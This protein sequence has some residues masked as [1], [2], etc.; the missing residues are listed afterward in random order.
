MSMSILSV[1]CLTQELHSLEWVMGEQV[2]MP[3][4]D[5]INE[6]DLFEA[7]RRFAK[8]VKLFPDALFRILSLYF[9]LEAIGLE[10]IPK[11]GKALIVPNHSDVFGYDAFMLA[12]LIRHRLKRVP[13]M[14][15]HPFWF[16]NPFFEAVARSYGIFPAD[17]REGLKALKH[18]K[19][20]IIFPEGADGNFKVSSRMYKLVE[21]NPGFVP[22]AIMQKAPVIP[23]VIIGAE[24]TH[25]NVAKIDAFKKI[26]GGPMPVPTGIL[27]RPAK[28][29]IIFLKPIDFSKYTKR[30][31]KDPRFV[32]EINQNI[33]Y[34][35][36][37][38]INKEIK[39]RD[40][41]FE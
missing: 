6:K 14:M 17:L 3:L 13:R 16:N 24:E 40:L 11:H 29:K 35:I 7:G 21:F 18:N 41:A 39:G 25:I 30:D 2:K 26:F 38:V 9:R 37:H 1:N 15:A 36:Q 32:K 5:W 28:W 31:I 10:N 8:M 23:T 22:L 34:R 19:L 20:V 33:R 12:E 4:P 27:P